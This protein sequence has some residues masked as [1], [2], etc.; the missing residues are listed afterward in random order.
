M[1]LFKCWRR[2]AEV[3]PFSLIAC[4]FTCVGSTLANAAYAGWSDS[5]PAL[6]HRVGVG[7]SGAVM[8]AVILLP[9]LHAMRLRD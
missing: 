1:K 6:L 9:W 3:I 4:F 8:V 5:F 2:G 7:Y